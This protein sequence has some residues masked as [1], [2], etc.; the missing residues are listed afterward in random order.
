MNPRDYLRLQLRLEGKDIIH[1]DLLRQ[2]EV[3]PGEELPLMIMVQFANGEIFAG[4]D[5]NLQ[6]HLYEE[7]TKRVRNVIF[8][9]IDLLFDFLKTQ[10]ISFVVGHYKTYLFPAHVVDLINK[11]VRCLSKKDTSV[12]AFG[13]GDFAEQV[14]VVERDGKIASACVSVCENGQCVEAWVYTAPE[15]RHRGL[16]QKVVSTWAGNLISAN[17]IPFYSHTIENRASTNLAIHLGLQSVFEEI[18][19]SSLNH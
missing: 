19:I 13:F 12:Q 15:F 16:A 10:N 9:T 7:L 2:V 4:Y 17:K 18:V 3:V 8:P 6:S 5:E 11:D 1:E 14:Y